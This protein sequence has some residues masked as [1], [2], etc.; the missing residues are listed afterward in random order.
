MD[1]ILRN[2]ERAPGVLGFDL[3]FFCPGCKC[4]HGVRVKNDG[5][6]P[7]WG[8]NNSYDKPTFTPS[9]L[10]N[11]TEFTERGKADYEAW[12]IAGC[13]K[14]APT[15]FESKPLICHTFVTDGIIHFLG[16]C[17]HYLANQQIPL[18]PF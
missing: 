5:P 7:V 15:S 14:P 3:I 4:G 9:I 6:G 10:I 1:K 8:W 17:T 2:V 12:Y 18:V 11:T 13:P 16:D